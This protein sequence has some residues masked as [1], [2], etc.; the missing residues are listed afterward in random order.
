MSLEIKVQI[1]TV[2]T[3]VCMGNYKEEVLSRIL[4][5]FDTHFENFQKNTR[6]KLWLPEIS[7]LCG[8]F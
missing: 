1:L 4:A 2:Y 6:S 8:L 3:D 5:N 7:F